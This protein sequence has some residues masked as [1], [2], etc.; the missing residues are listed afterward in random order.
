MS[1][2]ETTIAVRVEPELVHLIDEIIKV[3]VQGLMRFERAPRRSD[4]IRELL[5]AGV[6]AMNPEPIPPELL[7]E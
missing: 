4:I 2:L 3:R 7:E 1:R 6:N 5:V